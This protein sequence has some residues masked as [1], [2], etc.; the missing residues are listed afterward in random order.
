MVATAGVPGTKEF[1][2]APVGALGLDVSTHESV[3]T[4]ASLVE[5]RHM[6]LAGSVARSRK[7][8]RRLTSLTAPQAAH[9]CYTFGATKWIAAPYNLAHNLAVGPWALKVTCTV[10]HLSAAPSGHFGAM[11]VGREIGDGAHVRPWG[12][13]LKDNDTLYGYFTQDSG[14]AVVEC[15]VAI[16]TSRTYDVLLVWDPYTGGGTLTLYLDGVA[17]ASTGSVGATSQPK[18][19]TS[20]LAVVMIGGTSDDG[21]ATLMTNGAFGGKVDSAT[22]LAWPGRDLTTT[23]PNGRSLLDTLLRW[24]KIDWPNPAE[25]IFHYGLDEESGTVATDESDRANHGT[26][27]GAPTSSAG[28]N[29]PSHVANFVGTL[30]RTNTMKFV[31]VVSAGQTYRKVLQQAAS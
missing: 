11:I 22:L 4:A 7:G 9:G 18:Q 3:L 19:S 27:H 13:E 28:L 24:H 2:I 16:D 26:I 23:R 29:Y 5:C 15:H 14:G 30:T 17:A 25:A 6:R 20:A 31:Y 10:P 1:Q 12:L 8:M 21:G